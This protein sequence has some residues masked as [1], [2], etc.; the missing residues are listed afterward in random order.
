MIAFVASCGEG[1]AACCFS[2]DLVAYASR[3]WTRRGIPILALMLRFLQWKRHV[4][5]HRIVTQRDSGGRDL[6]WQFDFFQLSRALPEVTPSDCTLAFQQ[7]HT[8][9]RLRCFETRFHD[10]LPIRQGATS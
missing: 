4:K 8:W 1:V 7:R 2:A 6:S 10:R 3:W 9:P 5:E